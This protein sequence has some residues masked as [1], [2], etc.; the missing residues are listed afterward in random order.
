MQ[1]AECTRS[2]SHV[3]ACQGLGHGQLP[4]SHFARPSAL[5]RAFVRKR[6][7]ILKV[8]DQALG[9]RHRWPR[10]IR[11]LAIKHWIGRSRIGFASVRTCDFLQC[12]KAPYR[13]R[14]FSDETSTSEFAHNNFS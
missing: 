4:H 2:E 9:V 8:L 3:D 14:G 7:R 11:V 13:Y 1:F 5:V 10:G 6:K 12:S